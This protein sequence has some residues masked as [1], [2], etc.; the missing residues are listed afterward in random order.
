MIPESPREDAESRAE[1]RLFERLRDETSDDLV[2]FH[3]V[4]WLVPS[5]DGRP[6]EGEADFV[7]AHPSHGV[8]VVEVKGGRIRYDAKRARWA[9]IGKQGEHRIKDPFRQGRDSAH[10]LI[11]LIARAK[12]AHE[13]K[14][15]VGHA[16][17]FPDVR[18]DDKDLK[19]DAPREI[20][21]DAGDLKNL[22]GRIEQLFRYW[23]GKSKS[24]GPGRAGIGLLEKLLANDFELRRPLALD[25]ETEERDLLRL[26]EEQYRVLDLL[27][28]HTRVAICGC[29]GSGKTFLAAEK[30][31]RLAHHGFRVLLICFNVLLAQYLRQ[32]LADVEE[33][34]VF[35]FDGLCYEIVREA[36]REFPKDPAPGEEHEHYSELHR[37]FADCVDVAAGRYGALIVDEAQDIN[38]DW[39]LPL[40]LLL[41]DPDRSPLYVF[42]DDN[43]RLF[44]VPENL[45]VAGE[46]IQ[47]SVN[48]RNTQRIN[49]LVCQYYRGGTVE[50]LGPEGPPI[51]AHFYSDD[52]ELLK[53]LDK[54]VREWIKKAE[55]SPADIALLTPKS[56][57]RSAL[58]TVEEL[59]GVPL[60]DDPWETD[61]ILR[62]S[63]YRFKGLERLVVAMTELD[64]AREAAF[65]VGFSRPNVFLS[66]FCPESARHRLPWELAK[67]GA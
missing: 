33:V 63:I 2:A 65:Y 48:C 35:S 10:R 11:D 19:P 55:V 67:A 4:A 13:R 1:L 8:L 40:Q 18:V 7:L 16:V 30:A 36:G 47:L 6:R 17:A 53:Q 32:G 46:P 28:R 50:A 43:Q 64:G 49:A 51:D 22:N 25:L 37:E 29:A 62:A 21:I 42:F 44:P 52:K 56:A 24:P 14:M 66:V 39:W 60:T 34:D 9:S 12:G 31:R 5:D 27:A 15:L 20:V 54:C 41:E 59:G 26:T 3:S 45:P 61:K 57:D 23:K 38:P 58:W